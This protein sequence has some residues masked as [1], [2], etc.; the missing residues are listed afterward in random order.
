MS[1][2]RWFL[3]NAA[4]VPAA[5]A[6]SEPRHKQESGGNH[7]LSVIWNVAGTQALIK[8]NGANKPWREGKLWIVNAVAVYD[9]DNHD[10]IFQ[11]YYTPEWQA[12]SE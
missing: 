10:D 1:N 11:W 5:I 4:D 6:D 2:L 9:R 7:N 8:V 3:L 12:E